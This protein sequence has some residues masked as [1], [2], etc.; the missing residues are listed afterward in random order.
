[1]SSTTITTFTASTSTPE[2]S[3]SVA[4]QQ[5][6][7]TVSQDSEEE[8]SL[9]STVVDS[10]NGWNAAAETFDVQEVEIV[11]SYHSFSFLDNS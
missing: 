11:C 5:W 9:Y 4:G 2:S 7:S 3:L 6:S 1:M 8:A 10:A